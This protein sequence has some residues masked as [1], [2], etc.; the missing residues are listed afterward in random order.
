[1]AELESCLPA[2]VLWSSSLDGFCLSSIHTH[3]HTHTRANILIL[4]TFALKSKSVFLQHWAHTGI[5]T[6]DMLS[7][8]CVWPL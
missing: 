8:R 4:D 5:A 6:T 2:K 1:M 7:G 3:T